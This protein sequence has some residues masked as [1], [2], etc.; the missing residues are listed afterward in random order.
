MNGDKTDM[1]VHINVALTRVGV[2]TVTVAKQYY[3]FWVCVSVAFVTA[4]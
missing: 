4:A 1:Y 2:T 3:I